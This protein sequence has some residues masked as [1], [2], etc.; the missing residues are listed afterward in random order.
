MTTLI[1]KYGKNYKS[2][3]RLAYPIG[4]VFSVMLL[5]IRARKKMMA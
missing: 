5:G 4:F 2:L 3:L 1:G